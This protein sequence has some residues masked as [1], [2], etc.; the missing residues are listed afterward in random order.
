MLDS[1]WIGWGCSW[2]IG[3]LRVI[4]A[5]EILDFLEVLDFLGFL[6]YLEIL[7]FLDYLEILEILDFLSEL[8]PFT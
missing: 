7:G 8:F 4:A 5:E 1:G 6:D 3:F 2:W